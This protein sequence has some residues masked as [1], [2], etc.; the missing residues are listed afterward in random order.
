MCDNVRYVDGKVL[1]QKLK[2]PTF[3]EAFFSLQT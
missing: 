2:R 3:E 1:E